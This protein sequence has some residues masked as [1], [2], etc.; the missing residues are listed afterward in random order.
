MDGK[1]DILKKP[2]KESPAKARFSMA[3]ERHLN[4]LKKA[5][6]S[7]E[8]DKAIVPLCNYLFSVKHYFTSSSCSG[9]IIL[10]AVDEKETKGK[11]FF[12]RKWHEPVE[13]EDVWNALNEDIKGKSV[14]LKQEPFIIHIEAD[15]LGNI[16][17][18][19]ELCRKAGIRRY[20]LQ[21]LKKGKFMVELQGSQHMSVPLIEKG[22]LLT[23]R[24]YVN[25]LVG[26]ANEK[27]SRNEKARDRFESLI[28]EELK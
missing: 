10:L 22:K 15:S 7:G 2:R 26:K 25:Y 19:L 21:V 8:A 13:T 9:R 3:K 27:F 5:I 14:W 17:R 20:G 16:E 12:H 24:D 28:R 11:A 1:K 6:A 23:G 4:R 18:I